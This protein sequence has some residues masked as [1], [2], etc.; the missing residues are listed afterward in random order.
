MSNSALAD[1]GLKLT[2]VPINR[3]LGRLGSA[4]QGLFL[5]LCVFVVMLPASPRAA[6]IPSVD[7]GVFLYV[8]WRVL[9]GEVPYRDVW[10]HKPPLI[11]YIDALG[12]RIGNGTR[13]GV[14]AIEVIALLVAALIGFDLLRR[15]FG[16]W[17]AVFASFAWLLNAFLV[18]DGGNYTT[19]YGLPLQFACLWLVGTVA[20]GR[21][22]SRR[23]FIIG[24]LSG[25]LFFLKQ[26]LIG[27]PA[28]IALWSVGMILFSAD[29][30]TYLKTLLAIM[31]GFLIVTGIVVLYFILQGA[32]GAFWEAAFVFN[33]VYVSPDLPMMAHSVYYIGAMLEAAQ[34]FFLALVGWLL[35]L[36]ALF[37]LRPPRLF[38]SW[39]GGLERIARLGA[40]LEL[41]D[42]K[43]LDTRQ[44][45]TLLGIALI[46]FPIEVLLISAP[47]KGFDHYLL[48]LLPISALLAAYAFNFLLAPLK[49]FPSWAVGIFTTV[50]MAS[51]FFVQSGRLDDQLN[52][53]INRYNMDAINYVSGHTVASDQVLVWGSAAY[54]NFMAQR[55]SP[56]RFVYQNP[57]RSRDYANAP[58]ILEFLQDVDRN[59]PRL[60]LADQEYAPP[61]FRFPVT[62]PDIQTLTETIMAQY[63]ERAQ[64]RGWIVLQRVN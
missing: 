31:S 49:S 41:N 54:V 57:L 37:A 38:S 23:G 8:G 47:G 16:T 33:A 51:L 53:V 56:T 13:W 25:L 11:F 36:I 5:A 63:Q 32:L 1:P 60:I 48:A 20:A 18:M 9:A 26:S 34:L 7:S 39:R 29:K 50:L 28:T 14:W 35:S 3:W 55:T 46:A 15:A 21:L 10:D 17:A 30:R 42:V 40:D 6:P 27:I 45:A 62:S 44:D 52:R 64:F 2:G 24:V 43:Q 58:Q 12:L 19:E 4:A 22:S 61:L 59:K